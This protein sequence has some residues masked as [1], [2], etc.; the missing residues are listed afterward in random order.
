MGCRSHGFP[1][2]PW[3]TDNSFNR[4]AWSQPEASP[5]GRGIIAAGL[6]TG[7]VC[8]YDPVKIL[9][10]EGALIYKND[11]HTGSV[12]GLHWNPIKKNLLLSGGV[13]AEV[14]S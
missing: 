5:S 1:Q 7:E 4:L 10:K 3:L 12:R 11:K 14:R 13:N 9:A 2:V 8:L 6:E